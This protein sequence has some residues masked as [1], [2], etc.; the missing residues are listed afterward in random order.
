MRS[1]LHASRVSL[2]AC[3]RL[4]KNIALVESLECKRT[5]WNYRPS[6]CRTVSSFRRMTRARTIVMVA[7]RYTVPLLAIDV[8]DRR[9]DVFSMKRRSMRGPDN[10]FHRIFKERSTPSCNISLPFFLID[11]FSL[12]FVTIPFFSRPFST[13]FSPFPLLF[14][15]FDFLF[16]FFFFLF[17]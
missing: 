14:Y 16:F 15:F 3:S 8:Y 4:C 11:L 6:R 9:S 1:P 10:I 2:G 13:I 7:A 5:S 12:L 17:V